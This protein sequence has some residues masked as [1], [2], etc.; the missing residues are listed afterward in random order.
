MD[1][2]EL[3]IY[4]SPRQFFVGLTVFIEDLQK[5]KFDSFKFVK[6]YTQLLDLLNNVICEKRF[7]HEEMQPIE[8]SFEIVEQKKALIKDIFHT[9]E[10]EFERVLYMAK[11]SI[12]QKS[13]LDLI[14]SFIKKCKTRN[15][16]EKL[17]SIALFEEKN[18]KHFRHVRKMAKKYIKKVFY[19]LDA[20]ISSSGDSINDKAIK[21]IGPVVS[22]YNSLLTLSITEFDS[23]SEM[24]MEK[25]R[26]YFYL[27]LNQNSK[28]LL[29]SLL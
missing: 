18:T 28:N 8:L 22:F 17:D 23:E 12:Q 14:I 24:V 26:Q 21:K 2:D 16:V 25:K 15:L 29:L 13:A 19:L 1:A 9:S 20:F 10:G 27:F 3:K 11:M 5:T 6:E 4:S 7:R